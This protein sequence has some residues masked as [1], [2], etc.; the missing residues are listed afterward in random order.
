MI[1]TET[2]AETIRQT[3]GTRGINRGWRPLNSDIDTLA[4]DIA[5]ALNS[6]NATTEETQPAPAAS[7]GS[8]SRAQ[9]SELGVGESVDA[10]GFTAQLRRLRDGLAERGFE[11]MPD[12][13]GSGWLVEKV[14]SIADSRA[15]G[16]R[17]TIVCLCGSTRFE[18]DFRRVAAD[19]TL[20]G[21]IVVKPDVFMNDG[22][23]EKAH[24]PAVA[25]EAKRAL[26]EL[27]KRKIDLADEVLILNVGGYVGASTRSEIE[28]AQALGKPLSWLEAP[29][30]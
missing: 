29:D 3:W 13:W 11:V 30:A 2:I 12:G 8:S 5:Q 25:D 1:D 27:H 4:T 21:V 7:L 15:Q 28:Y 19:L 16:Q 20:Q 17:P 9:G 23:A 18:A 22:H 14:L 6:T 10:Y 26:D 24:L